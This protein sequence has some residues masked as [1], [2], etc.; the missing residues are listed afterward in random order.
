MPIVIPTQRPAAAAP[1]PGPGTDTP[2]SRQPAAPPATAKRRSDTP[3]P[4]PGEHRRDPPLS[5]PDYLHLRELVASL[6][7][8]IR[9]E[10]SGLRNLRILDV[11]CGRKPYF[12]LFRPFSSEYVGIDVKTHATLADC[13]ASAEALPF[14]DASFDLVVSTQALGYVGHL[15]HALRDIYRV[16]KPGGQI[17]VS[18]HGVYPFVGDYWRVTK[19]GAIQLLRQA[20]FHS[21]HSVPNGHALICL[22]A[23]GILFL[24]AATGRGRRV[25]RWLMAPLYRVANLVSLGLHPIDARLGDR[26]GSLNYTA[27]A[28]KPVPVPAA[29]WPA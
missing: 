20:G 21:V 22:V 15:R 6:K 10:L 1:V 19:P 23:L 3:H 18:L 4:W 5:R 26:F 11:G 28:R 29:D 16:I 2:L 7:A 17:L 25:P 24:D 27:F 12:P 9:S 13:A 14:A 8:F